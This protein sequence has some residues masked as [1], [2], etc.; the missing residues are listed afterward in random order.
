MKSP[1]EKQ[2][3]VY[4]PAKTLY[5]NTPLELIWE[6]PSL[7]AVCVICI[8]LYWF[9]ATSSRMSG[10]ILRQGFEIILYSVSNECPQ[11]EKYYDGHTSGLNI[12]KKIIPTFTHSHRLYMYK[13]THSAHF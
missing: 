5:T 2:Y 4:V 8:G 11:I 1:T 13:Y 12:H 3:V 9:S 10:T 7:S 6:M